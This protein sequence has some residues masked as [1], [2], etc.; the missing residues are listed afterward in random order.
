MALDLVI[1]Q[2]PSTLNVGKRIA[3]IVIERNIY[4]TFAGDIPIFN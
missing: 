4:A 2:F 3:V 1:V